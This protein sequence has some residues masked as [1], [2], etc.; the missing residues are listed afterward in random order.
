MA[1]TKYLIIGGGV[2][3]AK[4]AVAIRELDKDGRVILVTREDRYPYD[5][6]PLSKDFLTNDKMTAEDPESKDP[7]WYVENNVEIRRAATAT[8]IDRSAHRVDFSDGQSLTYEKLLLTTGASPIKP[9]I[10]G[11]ELENVFFLRTIDDAENLRTA[12]K[13]GGTAVMIGGGYIGL[14]V[15]ASAT[16]RGVKCTVID[17]QMRPWSSFASHG[18]GDF[19]RRRFEQ[20]GVRLV[21][22]AAAVKIVGDG[23]VS[24][25]RTLSGEEYAADFV[26]IGLGVKL[27]T[28]LARD[29]GLNLDRQG[30]IVVD[31]Y[32]LT[33]DPDIYAA[34]DVAAFPDKYS[35]A[36]THLEHYLNGSWQ[37]SIAGA[38][39]A[40]ES[41]PYDR[42]AYFYSDMF[43]IHMA[44]RGAPGGTLARMFG[45]VE[46]GTF[47]EIYAGPGGRLQMGLAV[48]TDE[49]KLDPI[50]DR[51]EA[52]IKVA[53]TVDRID[54]ADF[55]AVA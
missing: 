16:S 54:P 28:Q 27:N 45:A 52:L 5:R 46:S 29:A 15:S 30:A 39:L 34:G 9:D 22:D 2:A 13:R 42:V 51:L 49:S 4:A 14:E 18:A 55:A 21:S 43:D 8:H 11:I 47:V 10:D 17:K 33:S 41:T 26:V 40:G 25:V 53:E 48:S 3:S 19:V 31:Q 24:A 35:G 12:I 20:A 32:L 38:N 50:S 44:L 23:K 36:H 37:G 6:P 1:D 7:S